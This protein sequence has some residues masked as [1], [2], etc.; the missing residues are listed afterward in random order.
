VEPPRAGQSPPVRITLPD[1]EMVDSRQPDVDRVR[2]RVLG[3]EV[4]LTTEAPA[5]AMREADRTPVDQDGGVEGINREDMAVAAPPGTFFDY[6]VLHL[7][8]TG[9]LDRLR[10]LYPGGRFEVRRFR[11]NLVVAPA[12]AAA[13]FR[14]N[15]WL[16]R[17][18][19][20]GAEVRLDAIDHPAQGRPLPRHRDPAHAGPPQPGR[21]RDAGAGRGVPGRGGDL[22]LGAPRGRGSPGRPGRARL[23]RYHAPNWCAGSAAVTGSAWRHRHC[24]YIGLEQAANPYTREGTDA[25]RAR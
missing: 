25:H 11:P 9:T 17:P 24:G 20:I 7:L 21:Q 4:T 8:T 23:T 1:G 5:G 12:D 19:S 22:R 16:G 6:R 2:S 14:E 10:E 3:R 18:L 13:G 15:G